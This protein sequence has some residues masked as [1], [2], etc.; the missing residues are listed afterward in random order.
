MKFDPA[1]KI[2]QL[3]QFGEFGDVNPSIT[4]SS[5]YTFLHGSDMAKTFEG[6]MEGCFLYSRHWNPTN[7]Y[8]SEALAAMEDTESAWVT[9]SGMAAITC[10][11]L[12]LCKQ[13]DH[14]ITSVTTYGGTFAF[15]KNWLPKYGIEVTFVD[16]SD[17]ESIK[18]AIQKK[19]KVIYTESVTNPLLQVSDIPALS[20][21]AKNHN[22]QLMVDN[23]FTPMII[24]PKRLGADVVVYSMT[25]F[26]NGKNDCVAG[27]ICGTEKFISDLSNVNDGTAMLLGPVLDPMRSAS[28]LKNIHTLHIRMRQHSSN[29]MYIAER[30]EKLG[31]SIRY[32]GLES[33]AQHQLH[34][35]IMN[36][37][38]GFGGMLAID[39]GTGEKANEF[40]Q[41]LQDNG[42]GYLAVSLGYFKT[43]FSCSGKSTSSEIP[44][45]IQDEM[46]LSEGLVRFSVGLDND[47][48]N[49][50]LVIEKCLREIGMVKT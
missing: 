29:A 2:Q 17:L 10:A 12:Q 16:I 23:T 38:F 4:D 28:I 7:K 25:K 48:A 44:Q 50:Y 21:I 47:I 31:V 33:H 45:Q 18:K 37:S 41:G 42:V 46:G 9:G 34:K 20:V 27:A 1:S 11:L 26:I 36:E 5:T 49:S 3:K 13:G 35:Q 24:S 32:P 30:L 14:I 8:L 40:M 15:L 39:L 19:T 22:I 43:L 6:M